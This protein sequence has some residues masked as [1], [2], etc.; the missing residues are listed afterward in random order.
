[1]VRVGR[2]VERFRAHDWWAVA[3]ELSIVVVGLFLGL[4][5]NEWWEGREDRVLERHYL[6]RLAA[7]HEYNRGVV[8]ELVEA[9]QR[10]M[11]TIAALRQALD[12]G[13]DPPGADELDDALCRWFV[14]APQDL[15][16]GTYSELVSSGR[17]VLLRDARLRE[18][19]EL[20]E[21]RYE[22]TAHLDL[23]V[24]ILPRQVA[25]LDDYRRWDL[26]SGEDRER[27]RARC[28]FDLAGMAKDPRMISVLA[29]LHREQRIQGQFLADQLEAIDRV[30][31]A[32]ARP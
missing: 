25:A 30:Q 4:Q 19:L 23:F 1:V 6:E 18:L 24:D 3:I 8:S 17:L 26:G 22:A 9:S 13:A 29:Q 5:L 10:R 28:T 16:R 21:R 31:D 7:D 12:G 27:S 32:L 15:R 20:A 2:F 14:R 11:T